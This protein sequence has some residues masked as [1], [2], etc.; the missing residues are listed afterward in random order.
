[1]SDPS[2]RIYRELL[3]VYVVGA[4]E[5]YERAAVDDHLARCHDCREELAGLAPLTALLHR[6]PP[7]E[8][9][10]IAASGPYTAADPDPPAEMLDSLLSRT[11]AKRRTRRV[12][13]MFTAAAAILI[14]VGG[15][16][17]VGEAIASHPHPVGHSD[18]AAMTLGRVTATVRYGRMQWGTEMGVRV[19]GLPQGTNCTFYIVTKDGRRVWGGA[20][21]VGPK[22]DTLWYPVAVGVHESNLSGFVLIAGQ[23]TLHIPADH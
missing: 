23:R 8:A 3:G 17:A 5:P 20:W 12:K 2:C 6:V 10:R 14:A 18:V 13:A 19:T 11:A 22:A 4:I 21:T 1:M 16:T 9:E 7:E 15:A